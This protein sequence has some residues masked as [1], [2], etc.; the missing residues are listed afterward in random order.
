MPKDTATLVRELGEAFEAHKK[1]NDQALA[2]VKVHGE[3][4]GETK[5]KLATI[6]T[7]IEDLKAKC[8]EAVKAAAE[9]NRRGLGGPLA[10]P[11]LDTRQAAARLHLMAKR[12]RIRPNDPNLDVE[13]YLAYC[14]AIEAAIRV[15]FRTGGLSSDIRAALEV[16]VDPSGGWFVPP[17]MASEIERRVHDTSPMRQVARI[18]QIG[19]NA[20]EAPFR[21]NKGISG[22]W[23]TEKQARPAT[24]TA[25]G[26][27][28]RIEAH[29]QYAY[30]EVTQEMLED[31]V[32]DVQDMLTEE[33]TDQMSRDEN[34]AFVSGTGVEQPRGFLDYKGTAVT[35]KDASRAWGL[36]QY[37]A[38]GAAGAFPTV[39]GSVASDPNALIDMVAALNPM[40]RQG[41]TWA[42][43]RTTEATVR[44]LKD[45]DGR[46][47]VGFGDLR[48]DVTGFNLLGFPIINFEDM[49]DVASDS[50]SIA[51]A[52]FR[53]G[54]FIVDR[55]GF[56]LLVDPYTNK[57]FVGFYIRKRTGGDVRN[58]D[59]IKLM[60]FAAS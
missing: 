7:V 6:D 1:T 50:Y 5:A 39:S 2:E 51:F 16:G 31:A 18:I 42:M 14:D 26:G 4:L 60:K 34:L 9:V 36:L 43:N 35:T 47:L 40:Y 23:V 33:T 29:E 49:P 22:G 25:T 45:A 32:I 19:T 48:D 17:T 52:N 38:S 28:Q 59:A 41:A 11:N 30:P 56:T 15:E 37:I 54:Y 24:D 20:W 21:V 27:K 44:K 57:P 53:R 8:D 10:E 12:Q 46:Y 58:F 3:A 13:G 55:L